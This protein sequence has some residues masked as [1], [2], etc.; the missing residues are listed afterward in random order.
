[1]AWERKYEAKILGVRDKELKSQRLNYTIQ[2][3][4]PINLV[5]SV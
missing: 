5:A 1:M 2:V 3:G 4:A